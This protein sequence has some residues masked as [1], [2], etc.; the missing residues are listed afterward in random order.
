MLDRYRPSL[1]DPGASALIMAAA[2]HSPTSPR[3]P[4]PCSDC[5]NL[6]AE[7]FT[8]DVVVVKRKVGRSLKEGCTNTQKARLLPRYS[9]SFHVWFKSNVFKVLY[10]SPR[11]VTAPTR[12]LSL[13]LS[14]ADLRRTLDRPTQ[15]FSGCLFCLSTPR[16][17]ATLLPEMFPHS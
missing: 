17:L 1:F 16:S 12:T 6:V 10:R 3:Q 5:W 7:A 15:H 13:L 4:R 2:Q 11:L 8:V 9:I 14:P